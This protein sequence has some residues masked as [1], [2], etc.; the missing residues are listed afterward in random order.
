MRNKFLEINSIARLFNPNIPDTKAKTFQKV[1]FPRLTTMGSQLQLYISEFSVN[2]AIY[3]LL[4]SN[5][6]EI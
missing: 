5:N 4:A 6:Q 2:A 3:T 1:T